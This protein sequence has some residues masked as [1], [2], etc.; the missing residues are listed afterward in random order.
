MDKESSSLT[1]SMEVEGAGLQV[2]DGEEVVQAPAK[3]LDLIGALGSAPPEVKAVEAQAVAPGKGKEKAVVEAAEEKA[4]TT[5]PASSG[6]EKKRSF[7][8]NYCQRKFYTS[9]ALGGHQ[10]A[11]KR[12][13]SLA[14]HAA[15]AAA[16]AGRGLYGGA[17]PFLP[18]HHL[19]FPHAWPYSA[20]GGGGRTSSSSSLGLG[21]GSAAAAPFYGRQHG[22]A[23]HA[24]AHG[25]QPS[26]PGLARHAGAERPVY[27]P[28]GYGG[29]GASSRAPASP[30]VLDT[31]MAG[32]RWAGVASGASAGVNNGG[33]HDVTQQQEEAQSCK[34]DLNLRL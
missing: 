19:R 23:A 18:P 4:P 22:W 7:K 30:A 10:N 16:A 12:E 21:R 1:A 2:E 8:C 28:H 20:G 13:R 11:H 26:M 3:E 24:H 9:Q 5:A 6:G 32:L 27:A 15:A 34:I 14:K 29:Y 31:G 25:G 33:A 17:D